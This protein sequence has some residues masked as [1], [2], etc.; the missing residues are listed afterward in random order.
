MNYFKEDLRRIRAFV[1]D[2]DGVISPNEVVLHPSGDM[3]RTVSTRDGFAIQ[4]ALKRGFKVAIITGARSESIRK[5]F[6]DLGDVAVYLASADKVADLN[7]FI[8]RQGVSADQILY[9]GD[10]LPDY[11]VMRLVG[12][13]TCPSDA[14]PDIQSIALYISN[15]PG[16]SGC[17]RDI[18]EQVMRAQGCWPVFD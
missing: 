5:R 6:T 8:T 4:M 11:E 3:M 15:L 18:I 1:F 7:D 9:M 10:D 13:P 14:V 12:I 2:V 16:G 17:V